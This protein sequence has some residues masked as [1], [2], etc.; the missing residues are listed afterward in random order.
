MDFFKTGFLDKHFTHTG[1][2]GDLK[3]NC[4]HFLWVFQEYIT[5]TMHLDLS[6]YI[7][8]SCSIKGDNVCAFMLVCM[9]V[10][11]ATKTIALLRASLGRLTE[12]L[13]ARDWISNAYRRHTHNS[14]HTFTMHALHCSTIFHWPWFYVFT[15]IG[16]VT[17]HFADACFWLS[18]C[19]GCLFY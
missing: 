1:N 7:Y 11:L 5:Q 4:K 15:L 2:N 14:T 18:H 10:W 8:L 6:G 17:H 9:S 16:H 19:K 13:M 3:G 12:T